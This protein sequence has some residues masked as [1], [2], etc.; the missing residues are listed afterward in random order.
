MTKTVKCQ[1]EFHL[2]CPANEACFRP[3]S[4]EEIKEKAIEKVTDKPVIP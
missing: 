2:I 4:L 3:V 1:Y